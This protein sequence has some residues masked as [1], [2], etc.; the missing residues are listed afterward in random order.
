[1]SSTSTA[2]SAV[3]SVPENGEPLA[4]L[5]CVRLLIVDDDESYL[6]LCSRYLTKDTDKRYEI[7]TAA[8]AESA[9]SACSA[10]HFDCLLIDYGL[11]GG[12]GT[13][14]IGTLRS[15]LGST[16]PP[17]VLISA[18][19]SAGAATQAVRS[20]AADFLS[21]REVSASSLVRSVRNAVEKGRLQRAVHVRQRELREA[22]AALERRAIEIQ[23]FYHTVSHEMKTPLTAAREFVA[24]V[25]DGIGGP[26]TEEQR[27]LLGHALECCDQ[28]TTQFNDLIDL[29]RLETGK[30]R[31][32]KEPS[33]LESVTSR[34]LAM[35]AGAAS[36][37]MVSLERTGERDSPLL[38]I[39]VGRIVQVLSNLIG[40]AIK[41][42]DA[43]GR[44]QLDTQ[45][46]PDAGR[47]LVRVIDSGRGIEP[48]DLER[49]FDRLYQVSIAAD[50]PNSSGLGLGLSIA[51]EIV[52]GHDAELR[53]E[54]RVGLGSTF[55]F[56][57]PFAECEAGEDT[58][59]RNT[60][61]TNE[62]GNP[63]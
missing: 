51:R 63:R 13:E 57:L 29:T 12:T 11:R 6:T 47:V 53:V 54:S 46:E 30:L 39:D 50:D 31:L 5:E 41:F 14:L 62:D 16:L 10:N 17:F 27:E 28:I 42:T 37:K 36:T 59:Q 25:R 52:H 19:E 18:D 43:G 40:N 15:R 26:I 56:T 24:I 9:L 23:R 44:V 21:K 55:S 61:A 22:N 1:M 7:V 60:L 32:V 48:D 45:L 35:C 49:I 2:A 20:H 58:R 38:D 4:E 8:D 33:S 34:A 3:A